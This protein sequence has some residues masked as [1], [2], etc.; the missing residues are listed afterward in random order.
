[1]SFAIDVNVLVYASDRASPFHQRAV[2]FLDDCVSGS[3]V[4]YVAW[5]TLMSYLRIATHPR[6]FAQP[7]PPD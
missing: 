6:I 2:Q 1:M 5:A 3:D 7:F 4:F